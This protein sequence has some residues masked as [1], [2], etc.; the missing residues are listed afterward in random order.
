MKITEALIA[1]HIVFGRVFNQVERVLPSWTTPAGVR[2]LAEMLEGL[3]RGHEDAEVEFAYVPLDHALAE[4]GGLQ[5][6]YQDHRELDARF[7]AIRNAKTGLEARLMLMGAIA[8]S[9]E[10]FQREEKEVFPLLERRFP[11]EELLH[12]GQAWLNRCGP[13]RPTVE[14][15]SRPAPRLQ[16][17]TAQAL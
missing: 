10:H 17:L 5:A 4:D 13:P 16:Q 14:A 1:E 7:K 8:A 9:R 12:L 2:A 6:F 11:V 3:L 15:P